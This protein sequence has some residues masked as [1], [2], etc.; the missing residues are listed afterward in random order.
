MALA[1]MNANFKIKCLVQVLSS[2]YKCCCEDL[3]PHSPSFQALW[4][5]RIIEE[6]LFSIFSCDS[7]LEY[8]SPLFLQGAY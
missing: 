7:S 4:A 2:E 1:D 6:L 5:T 8:E 3:T